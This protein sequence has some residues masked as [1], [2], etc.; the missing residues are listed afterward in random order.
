[1][2]TVYR[3]IL[4]NSSFTALTLLQYICRYFI[5]TCIVYTAYTDTEY[6]IDSFN[7]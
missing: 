1:M 4:Y 3:I 6:N 2:C 5:Y 7:V